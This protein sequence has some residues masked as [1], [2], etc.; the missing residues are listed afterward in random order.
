MEKEF[1]LI[2]EGQKVIVSEEVYR[3]YMQPVWREERNKRNRWRC[4]DA[5]GVRCKKNCSECENARF[6]R[7]AIGN[8]LSLDAL[9][10]Q[11]AP[12]L[13]YEKDLLNDVIHEMHLEALRKAIN[14]LDEE[15]RELVELLLSGLK[16]KECADQLGISKHLFDYREKKVLKKIQKKM[17]KFI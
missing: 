5:K 15:D 10:E 13:A 12:C 2:I 6:G 11:E 16:K 1:Y 8:D 14:E 9:V 4:R 3:A 7:G 17:K